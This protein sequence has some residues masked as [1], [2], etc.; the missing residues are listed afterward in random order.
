M[1]TS[2]FESVRISRISTLFGGIGWLLLLLPIANWLNLPVESTGETWLIE[3]LLMLSVLVFVPL[4]LSLA[5]TPDEAGVHNVTFRCAVLLQPVGGLLVVLS[6]YVRTDF[7]AGAITIAWIL[8]T[9]FIALFGLWRLWC[10]WKFSRSIFPLHELCI[11]AGLAYVIVG[12]GWLFLSRCG[13][14]PLEFSDTIVLLTAVHFHYAGFAAPI[15]T[16]LAGRKIKTGIARKVYLAAASGVIAGPPLVAAGITLSRAV[17]VFSAVT[18]ALSLFVL[19]MLTMFIVAPRMKALPRLL[20]ILSSMSV[21]VTMIFA[22]LY[23]FGRFAG[24]E[25]VSIPLMA[26]IHG[27]SNALGFVLCG[28]AAW[29]SVDRSQ[30]FDG[31]ALSR[32]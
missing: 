4:A 7:L 11:D 23:A 14:N 17:E 2:K 3:R 10:R 6:F 21:I 29:L 27:I 32:L 26:Q 24:I 19:A 5:A 31:R 8:V 22:C 15:L 18:L 16:G 30:A 28:L 1:N 9:F 20:L 12:G 13:L 25:T